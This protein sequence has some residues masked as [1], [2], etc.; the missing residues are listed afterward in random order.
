MGKGL[1]YKQGRGLEELL[2]HGFAEKLVIAKQMRALLRRKWHVAEAAGGGEKGVRRWRFVLRDLVLHKDKGDKPK[3]PL[4][5]HP[6]FA[7]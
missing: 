7:K 1:R 3:P 5:P 4:Y 6:H 2:Q